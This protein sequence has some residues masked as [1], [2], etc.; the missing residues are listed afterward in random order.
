ML[1]S[2]WKFVM[3]FF[4][5]GVKFHMLEERSLSPTLATFAAEKMVLLTGPR[6][7]GK[8]TAARSW[9]ASRDGTYLSWDAPP[10]RRRILKNEPFELVGAVVLDELHKYGRWKSYVKGPFD[11]NPSTKDVAEEA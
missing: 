4:Q 3:T 7:V 8:T 10:D 11:S 1:T 2:N 5:C 9:L 6:Q